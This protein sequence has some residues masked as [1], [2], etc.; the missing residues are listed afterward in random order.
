MARRGFG[1]PD[2]T[3][4]KVN[5]EAIIAAVVTNPRVMRDM[6]RLLRAA[7]LTLV[8]SLS[9]VLA[10]IGSADFWLPAIASFRRL[11][12]AA[13]TMTEAVA[14]ELADALVEASDAGVFFG[15]SN[16]YSY[17]AVS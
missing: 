7:G 12:P 17:V 1:H 5:D 13:G 4:A 11:I 2:P 10:E 9:Y 3:Q 15:A 14:N 6:P 16:Y 8:R